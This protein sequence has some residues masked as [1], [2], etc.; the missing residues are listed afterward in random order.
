MEQF[1]EGM[2]IGSLDFVRRLAT[3][4]EYNAAS[5]ILYFLFAVKEVNK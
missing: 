5:A 4:V 3:W 1:F 2:M